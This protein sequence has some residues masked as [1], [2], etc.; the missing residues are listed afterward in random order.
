[1]H[2][3]FRIVRVWP[4]IIFCATPL[5]SSACHAQALPSVDEIRREFAAKD[6]T[7]AALRQQIAEKDQAIV[8]LHRQIEL[9]H[10]LMVS[11]SVLLSSPAHGQ[12]TIS[13]S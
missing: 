13:R 8:S 5:W 10:P 1:M 12:D 7:I 2:C 3:R 9:S 4:I 11:P 6:A